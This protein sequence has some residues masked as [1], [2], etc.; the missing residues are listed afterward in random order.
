MQLKLN[1]LTIAPR[2]TV[3]GRGLPQIEAASYLLL[4]GGVQWPRLYS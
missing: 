4:N 3:G 1:R 2:L